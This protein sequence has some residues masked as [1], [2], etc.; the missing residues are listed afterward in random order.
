MKK[1]KKL[2][3]AIIV[4]S[5]T[6]FIFK[7]FQIYSRYSIPPQVTVINNSKVELEDITLLGSG[8]TKKIGSLKPKSS[9]I[10]AVHPK[11]ESGLEI[12]FTV[13]SKKY[14]KDDL[15]YIEST[16]GYIVRITID[17]SLKIKSEIGLASIN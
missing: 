4:I 17:E 3:I 14:Q 1:I 2:F 6:F 15:A 7:G 13:K 12:S 5:A 9:L 8:F 16:G 10:T 11:G